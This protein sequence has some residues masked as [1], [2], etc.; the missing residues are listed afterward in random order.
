VENPRA[1]QLIVEVTDRPSKI[2]DQGWV[3][4][5]QLDWSQCGE[6]NEEPLVKLISRNLPGAQILA[7]NGLK[8][9]SNH[10]FFNLFPESRSLSN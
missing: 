7:Q 3:R 1:R 5:L 2:P 6:W 9:P 4:T 8:L 10:V